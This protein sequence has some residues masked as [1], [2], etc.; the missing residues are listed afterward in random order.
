MKLVKKIVC[1]SVLLCDSA[2]LSVSFSSLSFS[3]FFLCCSSTA[4]ALV[5]AA[6]AAAAAVYSP[7][8]P[9][10]LALPLRSLSMSSAKSRQFA[11]AFECFRASS[12]HSDQLTAMHYTE[13]W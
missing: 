3:F 4:D 11:S 13:V 12:L 2:S 10:C 9:Q 5:A 8:C 6:A 7:Q 1:L